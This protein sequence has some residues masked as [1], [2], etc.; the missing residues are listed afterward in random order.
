VKEEGEKGEGGE[1]WRER[2]STR[3]VGEGGEEGERGWDW[4]KIMEK[5]GGMEGQDWGG[6]EE[7]KHKGHAK[8]G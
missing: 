6:K 2:R 5:K 1:G 3:D 4:R 7:E 8:E